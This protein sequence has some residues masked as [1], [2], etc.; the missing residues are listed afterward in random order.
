MTIATGATKWPK[1]VIVYTDG[2]SRGNPGPA[3]IGVYVT[4]GDG[5]L[6]YELAEPLGIQTNNVAEYSAVQRALEICLSQKVER[7]EIRSDS[8]LLVR[9]INGEYRVKSPGLRPLYESCL[10]L[11][12]QIPMFKMTHVRRELNREADRLANEALDR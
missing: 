2:A 1:S 12:R 5:E 10:K 3:A 8:E 9:Q 4:S 7:L 6:L 11:I